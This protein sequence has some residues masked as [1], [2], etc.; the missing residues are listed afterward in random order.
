MGT[1]RG[2]NQQR[3]TEVRNDATTAINNWQPSPIET[4]QN[5]RITTFLGD[6]DAGKDVKD[7]EYIRPY[8]NLFQGGVNNRNAERVGGGGL[9]L[10]GAGGGQM[11]EVMRQQNQLK[12]EEAAAGQLYNATNQA[13]QYASGALAPSLMQMNENRLAGKAQMANQNY[14]SFLNRPKQPS[15]W[16]QLLTAGIGAAG[17]AASGS[18]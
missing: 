12:K 3:E 9:N 4:T 7:I 6:M 14:Q 13:Y 8:F 15:P 1:K 18:L 5:K 17:T 16:L 2:K 10:S 11:A